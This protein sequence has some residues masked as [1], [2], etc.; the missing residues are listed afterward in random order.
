MREPNPDGEVR[1]SRI[2]FKHKGNWVVC[3]RCSEKEGREVMF[4]SQM[5][6]KTQQPPLQCSSCKRMDWWVVR[7]PKGGA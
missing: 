5:Y 2:K 6:A 1:R 3:E 4:F 7:K